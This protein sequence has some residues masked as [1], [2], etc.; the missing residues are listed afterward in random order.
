MSAFK[1]TVKAAKD[2]VSPEKLAKLHNYAPG[3]ADSVKRVKEKAEGQWGWC[4]VDV[5]ASYKHGDKTFEATESMGGSSYYNEADFIVNSGYFDD[6]V[7][8]AI[9][10]LKIKLR[11]AGIIPED[12][13]K[14]ERLVEELVGIMQQYG[15]LQKDQMTFKLRKAL[16]RKDALSKFAQSAWNGCMANPESLSKIP[17]DK[18]A[19]ALKIIEELSNMRPAPTG[20][21]KK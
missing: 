20:A 12:E 21:D 1:I 4:T 7:K 6:M 10:D 17:A 18:K 19:R 14:Y 13:G 11:D 9:A 15:N 5:T 16:E 2:D 3:F 8:R